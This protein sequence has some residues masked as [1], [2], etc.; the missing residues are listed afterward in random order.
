MPTETAVMN[1]E[2]PSHRNSSPS[3]SAFRMVES[4]KSWGGAKALLMYSVLDL[5]ALMSMK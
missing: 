2:L 1:S 4:V 5:N 3:A